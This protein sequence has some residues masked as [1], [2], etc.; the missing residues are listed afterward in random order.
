MVAA[1]GEQ[2]PCIAWHRA[3]R[4]PFLTPDLTIEA[5]VIRT[6]CRQPSFFIKH[7]RRDHA[8]NAGNL[9]APAAPPSGRRDMPRSMPDRA[10][11]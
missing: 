1:T 8:G 11:A 9:A 7:F 10:G 3:L 4:R 2:H 5:V 6:A